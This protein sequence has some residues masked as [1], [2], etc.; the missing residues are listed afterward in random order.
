MVPRVVIVTGASQGI[1]RAAALAFADEGAAV[2]VVDLDAERGQSVVTE[3]AAAGG[4]A[5]LVATDISDE[6]Q[7]RA[8]IEQVTERWGR[9]DVLVNNAGVYAQ[10][11]AVATS[12]ETWQRILA[13]NLTGAFLCTKH[14]APAMA[15]GGVIVNVSSEAGLVGI[16]GQVAYNVSKG[17]LISLTQSCAV[18]FADRGIRVNT[19]CPGTTET[20]LVEKALRE[21][22]DAAA[23]RRELEEVRPL[24]RLGQPEEIASAIVFAA[25]PDVGYRTGAVISIDGGYTAR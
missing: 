17:G 6:Q 11:D 10:A 7:V 23:T 9:L 22:A 25:S 13:T 18:D 8:L 3:A 16:G 1:G 4:E 24:N 20:P 15:D 12:L 5:M 21:S 19:V 14:A 2:A